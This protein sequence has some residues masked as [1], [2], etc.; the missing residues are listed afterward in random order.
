MLTD[1]WDQGISKLCY[2]E[3]LVSIALL[4]W[5][6]HSSSC[7]PLGNP[8]NQQNIGTKYLDK[9]CWMVLFCYYRCRSNLG[10]PSGSGVEG[11]DFKPS[12]VTE[13]SVCHIHQPRCTEA[14]RSAVVFVLP[15]DHLPVT[16]SMGSEWVLAAAATFCCMSSRPFHYS[17]AECAQWALLYLLLWA[18][19]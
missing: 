17:K 7:N 13:A 18:L 14:L 2:H 4:L 1:G 5:D 12:R 6:V 11:K 19:R 16:I 8:C 9:Y 3:T 15:H 10:V